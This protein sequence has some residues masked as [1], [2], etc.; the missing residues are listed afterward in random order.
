LKLAY[1]VALGL[2]VASSIE[3][4]GLEVAFFV[5]VLELEAYRCLA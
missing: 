5:V 2:E 3:A 1:L 4:L